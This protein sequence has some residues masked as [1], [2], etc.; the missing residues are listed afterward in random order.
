ME[1]EKMDV[2]ARALLYIYQA[3]LENMG[4]KADFKV[5]RKKKPEAREMEAAG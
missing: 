2:F 1:E 3:R 5:V 4:L